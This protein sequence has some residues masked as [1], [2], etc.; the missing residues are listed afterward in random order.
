MSWCV[1]WWAVVTA[2][3]I[4]EGQPFQTTFPFF[5]HQKK[6]QLKVFSVKL[7]WQLNVAAVFSTKQN[8][9]EEISGLCL[10][11]DSA[12][13]QKFFQCLVTDDALS[14]LLRTLISFSKES[15]F[16]FSAFLSMI[17]TA[18]IW[19]SSLLSANLTCENAPLKQKIEIKYWV[20]ICK[21]HK[22]KYLQKLWMRFTLLQ[23]LFK[24]SACT[25]LEIFPSTIELNCQISFII[26]WS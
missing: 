20:S 2:R 14:H 1:S 12:G 19:P 6:L 24:W 9:W 15:S 21:G 26:Y 13:G 23:Q 17:F 11:K 22:I 4:K 10:F 18:Y 16:P 8:Q 7:P 5:F 25:L 3:L